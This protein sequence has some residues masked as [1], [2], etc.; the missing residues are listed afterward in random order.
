ML[1]MVGEY[2]ARLSEVVDLMV[3]CYVSVKLEDGV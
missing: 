2:V 1:E 3:E